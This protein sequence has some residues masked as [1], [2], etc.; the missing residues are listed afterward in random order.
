MLID[1]HKILTMLHLNDITRI[2]R[3][4]SQDN[5][6]IEC[7]Q[8]TFIRTCGN[9]DAEMLLIRIEVRRKHTT[10]RSEEYQ[11]R[12]RWRIVYRCQVISFGFIVLLAEFNLS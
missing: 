12:N 11:P 10:G 2:G 9:I 6:A 3:I 8:D 1:S 4:G 7:S 5:G